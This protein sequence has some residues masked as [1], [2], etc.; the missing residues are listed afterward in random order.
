MAGLRVSYPFSVTTVI[1]ATITAIQILA[2]TNQ[3]IRIERIL[4]HGLGVL[5]TDKPE[6]FEL[7]TQST[8]GTG[9]TIT[10][11][12]MNGS[13]S[14]TAQGTAKG[15]YTVEPTAGTVRESF[16]VHPQSPAQLVYPP[17]RDLLIKGGER[18]ALRINTPVAIQTYVGTIETEE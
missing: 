18:L 12:N 4:I 13:D 15:T 3:K 5:N 8:A 7:L 11:R 14:E 6:L 16:A 10:G 2:P 1:G 17:G 9:S